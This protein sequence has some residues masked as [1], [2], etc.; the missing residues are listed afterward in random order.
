[1]SLVRINDSRI[2]YINGEITCELAMEF[3]IMLLAMENESSD[4]IIIYI[5]S[6]G[7]DVSAG[8]SMIDTMNLIRC[9]V[10]TVCVGMAAS[11]GAMI[12]MNGK[13]GLRRILPH[14]EVLI[15]QPLGSLN[16][17][18]QATDIEIL[19]KTVLRKRDALYRIIHECT[20]QTIKKISE[21]CERDYTMNAE[22]A[23]AYG[24]VDDIICNHKNE[25]LKKT[26]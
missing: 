13:K 26:I 11:M 3:N 6:N 18:L 12:L 8:L 25:N 20:G 1:M 22:E 15:H 17:I 10:E 2:I 9:D 14:S 16:G 7:G 21:D 4:N 24:I 23:L 19:A 5:N